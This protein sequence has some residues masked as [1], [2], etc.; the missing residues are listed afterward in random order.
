MRYGLPPLLAL[1]LLG[2]ATRP[3]P[4]AKESLEAQ[5]SAPPLIEVAAP[6]LPRVPSE[7][8]IGPARRLRDLRQLTSVGRNGDARFDLSGEQLLYQSRRVPGA[9]ECLLSVGVDGRGARFVGGAPCPATGA[10]STREG[11]VLSTR[12]AGDAADD[13]WRLVLLKKGALAPLSLPPALSLRDA[14]DA[15]YA[16]DA[17]ELYFSALRAGRRTIFVREMR[18][19]AVRPLTAAEAVEGAPAPSPDGQRV[20]FWRET[21]AGVSEIYL[22]DRAKGLTRPLT[23]LGARSWSPA[24]HPSGGTVVFGSSYYGERDHDL[25]LVDVETAAVE[26]V[27]YHPGFDGLPAFDATGRRLAWTSSRQGGTPQLFIADWIDL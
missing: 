13:S 23:A 10:A 19:G 25:L 12:G 3:E 5:A 17:G 6:E 21:G 24:M 1:T 14:R 16:A 2:C 18:G 4:A 26:R 27:T 15:V 22:L 11:L 8:E 7:H 20:A 9:A